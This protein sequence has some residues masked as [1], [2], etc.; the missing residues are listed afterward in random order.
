MENTEQKRFGH[1]LPFRFYFE[2]LKINSAKALK[3]VLV[4]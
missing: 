4:F 3:I 1:D 2:N